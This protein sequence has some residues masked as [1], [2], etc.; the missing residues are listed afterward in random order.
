MKLIEF[1]SPCKWR[2][3]TIFEIFDLFLFQYYS[4]PH[5]QNDV[6]CTF[7]VIVSNIESKDFAQLLLAILFVAPCITFHTPCI[8]IINVH[9]HFLYNLSFLKMYTFIRFG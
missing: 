9:I 4:V 5:A 8:F 7:K 6:K 3:Q 1:G 2:L